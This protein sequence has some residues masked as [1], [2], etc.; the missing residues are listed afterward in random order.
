MYTYFNIYINNELAFNNLTI[1]ETLL[2]LSLLDS[3][4]DIELLQKYSVLYFA[5]NNI[6]IKVKKYSNAD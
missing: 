1:L 4:I 5:N 3:K 6:I 2:Q